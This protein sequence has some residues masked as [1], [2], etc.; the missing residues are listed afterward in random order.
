MTFFCEH[1]ALADHVL[2]Q[3]SR[4]NMK[5]LQNL[6]QHVQRLCKDVL[7]PLSNVDKDIALPSEFEE[8]IT[9]FVGY[10]MLNMSHL[11]L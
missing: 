11:S 6:K 10:A 5:K 1:P 2:L 4:K 8:D 3:T 9:I 7:T